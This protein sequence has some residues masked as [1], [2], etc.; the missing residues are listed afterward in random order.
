M[1]LTRLTI[2]LSVAGSL[3]LGTAQAISIVAESGDAASARIAIK[4][5]EAPLEVTAHDHEEELWEASKSAAARRRIY[6]TQ[7]AQASSSSSSLV[8][9]PKKA[10]LSVVDQ[11]DIT[12]AH[13][14]I[15]D[16]T[17]RSIY[18]GCRETLKNFYVRYD[19]PEHRGLG[20]GST[21]IL[22]GN[23]PDE[24]FRA[25]LVHECGHVIDTG[26]WKGTAA[27]GLTPFSDGNEPVYADD[28]SY[29]FYSLSWDK[30]DK[31]KKGATDA[32]FVSGY[33]AWNAFEDFAE[34]F[35]YYTLHRE[36]FFMR[37]QGNAVLMAKYRFMET[38]IGTNKPAST[39]H[40]WNGNIPWD[41]TKLPYAWSVRGN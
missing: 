1:L 8:A 21:I 26:S 16:E 12:D 23:V 20:G 34:S 3:L 28:P 27:A 10:Y 17:L 14:R 4:P 5:V 29:A 33:G 18:A 24:E 30:A 36:E 6:R 37:A 41:I 19:N 13:K 40:R 38:H 35:A 11:K 39:E 15:A 25:L 9:V 22:S 2:G 32:D 7:R 31:K